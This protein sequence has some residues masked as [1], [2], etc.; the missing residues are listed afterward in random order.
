MLISATGWIDVS[1]ELLIDCLH[2]ARKYKS[3]N[4]VYATI[5][6]QEDISDAINEGRKVVLGGKKGVQPGILLYLGSVFKEID[7]NP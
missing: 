2:A 1:S 5:R 6:S 7:V 4:Y 3:G